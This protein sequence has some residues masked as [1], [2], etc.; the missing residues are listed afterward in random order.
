MQIIFVTTGSKN[1]RVGQVL[2]IKRLAGNETVTLVTDHTAVLV[3]LRG[4]NKGLLL[5]VT[6]VMF[7]TTEECL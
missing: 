4:D 7:R 6:G 5:M 3:F 1:R 2:H